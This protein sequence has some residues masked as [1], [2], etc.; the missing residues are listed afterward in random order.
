MSRTVR[1][2]SAVSRLLAR[3]GGALILLSA[4]LISL[5]VVFRNLFKLSIFESFELTGYAI[6]L[7][8]SFG[9]SWALITKAHIRIEVVYGAL[10]RKARGLLDV[11]ALGV[12]PVFAAVLVFFAARVVL[13]N[14]QLDAHSN[15]TLHIPLVIPQGLWLIGL[16]WF[17]LT[18]V[19]LFVVA[20]HAMWRGRP[21][22]VE[23]L[24]GIASVAEEVEAS[25]EGAPAG[26][27]GAGVG[28][29]QLQPGA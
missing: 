10:P 7:A 23:K 29:L 1:S 4:I 6:A 17:A 2:V 13:D 21:E 20:V 3:L 27:P 9:L 14:L 19:V 12:L 5:D 24:F 11:A 8:T 26:T 25:L 15:S 16:G 28:A 18:T 22:E